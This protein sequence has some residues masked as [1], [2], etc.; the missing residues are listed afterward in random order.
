MKEHCIEHMD[1][2]EIECENNDWHDDRSDRIF[3]TIQDTYSSITGRMVAKKGQI[4]KNCRLLI[5][6]L[7]SRT[8]TWFLTQSRSSRPNGIPGFPQDVD[9]VDLELHKA[10]VKQIN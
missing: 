4:F 1:E 5:K 9:V 7:R 2:F 3:E 8:M 10:I 6:P